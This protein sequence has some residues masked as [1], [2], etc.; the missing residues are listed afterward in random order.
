MTNS[1]L[2][3]FLFLFLYFSVAYYGFAQV[4]KP[5]G[6]SSRYVLPN[7]WALSP[8]GNSIRLG[9]LPLNMAL[10]GSKKYLAVTNNGQ[11]DQSIE[12]ID[13]LSFK[14]LD[15]VPIHAAW[16][17]LVFSADDKYLFASGGND[18]C[19]LQFE[20][21]NKRL[22]LKDSLK[23]GNKWPE[24]ISPTGIAVDDAKQLLYVVTK[25]N[26]ALYVVDMK[27][28]TVIFKKQIGA[29]GYTCLLSPDSRQLYISCWGSH[30]VKVFDT[31]KRVFGKDF[32]VGDHPNDMCM[33]RKG[34]FLFVANANDNSVSVL[35][36]KTGRV[37]ETLNAALYPASP[38]GSTT[39]SVALSEDEQTLYIAN[40]DNN[41]LAVF[42]VSRPGLSRSKG[43]IPTGWYPTC[44]RVVNDQ[45]FVSNGK[46]F[47]SMANPMGPNPMRV[48][49]KVIYHK[50]SVKKEMNEQYIGGL[51]I[52]TLSKIKE[53]DAKQLG[54][55]SETVYSN[56]PYHKKEELLAKGEEGNPIPRKS[57]SASPIKYVY[58]IIKENRTYD[59]VLGDLQ[60]GNGDTSLVLFGEKI[61]PNQ[62]ALAKEF[63][64]FDNFYV[65]GEV[66]AD[67]HNWS[68]GAY[69]NDYLEKTWPTFYGDRG[70]SYDSE[71]F[72]AAAN[73]KNGF[74]WDFCKKAKVS[75]RTYGEFI[76]NW[77][78]AVPV[79][80]DHFC[81]YYNGWDLKVMD[82]TRYSEWK[83]DF[84]SL[85]TAGK[86]PHMNTLR[87][88]NDHTEGLTKGRPT[89]NAYMADNDLA[90]G[91]FIEHLSKSPIWKETAVFIVEDDAQNGSDHV[92]AH[93]S[94]LYLAGGFVKRGFV[95]HSMYS[96]S[97][98]L[99][100]IELI[101]GLPP[102]SQYDAAA[103]SMWKSFSKTANTAPFVARTESVN[104]TELVTVNNKWTHKC[105]KFDFSGEDRV[106]DAELNEILWV[107]VKGES[108]PCPAPKH[109]AFL[110]T[111][112]KKDED[113]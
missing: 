17:G 43:F 84:D 56:T 1:H 86:V 71:G 18:N 39:N 80:K 58:Y 78:P 35:D 33:T 47:S 12:L 68:N 102:M 83:R 8:A 9:D 59:Q 101:L 40:A 87:F 11:S 94:T 25:E 67:G 13:P 6:S 24:K 79:L 77:K 105:E 88:S 70:G 63:V 108:I 15:S 89:P 3:S 2:K 104:L 26:D 61:T 76:N 82:T 65:D 42:D 22:L 98:V 64:L 97:S 38:S 52:G 19:I 106:P 72:R 96:T 92:D 46:G 32:I 7:G 66:S 53:P 23:L 69:A 55:W 107:A 51:F 54:L 112:E 113:D 44:V 91:L 48:G 4:D 36:L 16:M 100:T 31:E 21:N 49:E 62:H 34:N 5:T 73:N 81:R 20:I 10:S 60:D 93:R 109:A 85:L 45:I 95:D 90:V 110:K 50:G 28:H 74:I 29:E 27:E 57:G 41:C 111:G 30:V 37:I 75:Y 99:H 103:P 14:L